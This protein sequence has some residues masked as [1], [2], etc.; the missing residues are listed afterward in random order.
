MDLKPEYRF[1]CEVIDAE[2]DMVVASASTYI[3]PD[4]VSFEGACETVDM[5]VA[6]LL[7]AFRSK[8][9][10]EYEAA[11]YPIDDAQ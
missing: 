3:V 4:S 10:E 8:A 11:H 1:K 7:R 5:E 6:A 9:R 2:T